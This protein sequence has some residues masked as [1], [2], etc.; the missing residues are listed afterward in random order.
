[1]VNKIILHLDQPEYTTL[2]DEAIRELRTPSD[3]ARWL[4]RQALGIAEEPQIEPTDGAAPAKGHNTQNGAGR[5][6]QDISSA[7]LP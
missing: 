3:Q 1:M 7:V 2:L 6:R 4:L 5:V